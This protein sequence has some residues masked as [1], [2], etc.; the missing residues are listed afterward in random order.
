MY[1]DGRRAV[2]HANAKKFKKG[3]TQSPK[4]RGVQHAN[5]GHDKVAPRI[6]NG[7]AT[8]RVEQAPA[9]VRRS[10]SKI[11]SSEANKSSSHRA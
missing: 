5:F 4:R 9:T 11:C 6:R 7:R 3:K 1:A 8:L 2:Q 10:S